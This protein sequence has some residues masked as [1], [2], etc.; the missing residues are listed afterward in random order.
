MRR[1]SER[2]CLPT[3]HFLV[4]VSQT[5]DLRNGWVTILNRLDSSFLV[6]MWFPADAPGEKRLLVGLGFAFQFSW[7]R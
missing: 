7:E 3:L 5:V 6:S 2:K 4:L 1:G